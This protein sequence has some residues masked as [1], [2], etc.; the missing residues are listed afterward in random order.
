MK[1]KNLLGDDAP[2][3]N[4]Y[5]CEFFWDLAP[6]E[7]NIETL[8]VSSLFCSAVHPLGFSWSSE[9]SGNVA[10]LSLS[11]RQNLCNHDFFADEI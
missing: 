2:L 7:L 10:W 9:P 8:V 11:A 5:A 1:L 6:F 3:S 4:N